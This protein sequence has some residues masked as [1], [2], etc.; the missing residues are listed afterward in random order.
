MRKLS[1]FSFL[2]KHQTLRGFSAGYQPLRRR[3]LSPLPRASLTWLLGALALSP[4]LSKTKSSFQH[5]RCPSLSSASNLPDYCPASARCE[6]CLA[7]VTHTAQ[8]LFLVLSTPS[9]TL[10]REGP[11]GQPSL[12]VNG[13]IS[14]AAAS[15]PSRDQAL[16]TGP[17]PGFI[18][19]TMSIR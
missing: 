14:E 9:G 11:S 12:R 18:Q 7:V 16:V 19:K 8:L 13:R 6:L 17:F 10:V 4:P 2:M 15:C 3:K 1:H 5:G